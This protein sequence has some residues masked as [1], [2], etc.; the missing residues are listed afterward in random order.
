M[1][2]TLAVS[3][4]ILPTPSASD[5]NS[6]QLETDWRVFINA[7][8]ASLTLTTIRK[9]LSDLQL[10]NVVE[11][12]QSSVL[13]TQIPR[14]ETMP[15]SLQSDAVAVSGRD[16]I[17]LLDQLRSAAETQSR[18]AFVALV[19]AAD[20]SIYP[21]TTLAQA[22]TMAL[23]QEWLTTALDLARQGAAL[24]PADET[25]QRIARTLAPPIA[26]TV[27]GEPPHG[28][29]A[30][31]SWLRANADAYHG[32]WVA[33]YDGQLLAAAPSLEELRARVDPLE[34]PASTIITRVL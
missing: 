8:L 27:P 19:E 11:V 30:S 33:V 2:N 29:A 13:P 15:V 5:P 32:Q 23:N 24:F 17:A 10:R 22:V 14:Y 18:R 6:A 16:T 9:V 25:V 7:R 31:R 26:H 34:R 12:D 4:R 28:L 21:P 3:T 1:T 20:W